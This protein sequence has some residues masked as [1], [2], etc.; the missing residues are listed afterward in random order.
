[1]DTKK[2]GLKERKNKKKPKETS[3]KQIS[4]EEDE[5]IS[6]SQ[7]GITT[8]PPPA[9]SSSSTNVLKPVVA[10]KVEDEL[11]PDEKK[12]ESRRGKGTFQHLKRRTRRFDL[13]D[14]LK[15]SDPFFHVDVGTECETF[16]QAQRVRVQDRKTE[17]FAF[18]VDLDAYEYHKIVFHSF[19]NEVIQSPVF[20]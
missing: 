16:Y 4:A 2:K 7:E 5:P 8:K 11:F 6:Y 3:R 1:M 15:G 20:R 18:I 12:D 9:V 14:C 10:F 19:L 13:Q 17:H